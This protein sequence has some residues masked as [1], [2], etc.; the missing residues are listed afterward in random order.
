MLEVLLGHAGYTATTAQTI[1]EAVELARTQDFDLFLLDLWMRDG[2]RLELCRRMRAISPC[3][4]I[5]IYSAD[6]R[7]VN[8]DELEEFGIQ[9][10]LPKPQGLDDLVQVIR[11]LVER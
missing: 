6:V 4:P 8:S 10:F 3:V 1:E 5:V 7:A 9:A 11:R 2:E